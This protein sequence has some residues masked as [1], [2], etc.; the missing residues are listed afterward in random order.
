MAALHV[1]ILK[2]GSAEVHLDA[3]NPLY[4]NGAPRGDIVRIPIVGSFNR[5]LFRLHRRWEHKRYGSLTRTSAN[6]YHLMRG[7]VQLSF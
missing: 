6:F 2:D 4:I 5:R 3:F 7:R 1:G